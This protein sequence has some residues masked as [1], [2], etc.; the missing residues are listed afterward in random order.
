MSEPPGDPDALERLLELEQRES[1]VSRKRR[2][3]HRRIEFVRGTG[4]FEPG[5]HELLETLQDEERE[6]SDERRRLHLQ[7]DRLR[8]EGSE[9]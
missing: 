9:P 3:L 7:I 5:T 6:L 1:A 2:Q 8:A 4:M